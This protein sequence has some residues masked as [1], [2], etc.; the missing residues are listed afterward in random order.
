MFLASI[1]L[2]T[3]FG[4]LL[5]SIPLAALISKRSG[6]N[7]FETGNG[8]PGASNV[9]HNV[10]RIPAGFVLL[11]DLVKGAMAVLVS[12]Y[13]GL[14]EPWFVIPAAAA[15][16]GHWRSLFTGFKGGDGL[17]T[18]GGATIAMFPVLGS[19]S[20]TLGILVSLGGQR[21]PYTSL[22]GI[23]I[24]YP[25]LI[26]FI[27]TYG[28]DTSMALGIAAVSILVLTHALIGHKR[29]RNENQWQDNLDDALATK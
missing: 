16:F 26:A 22:M 1:L 10:G 6:I 7:I 4:Y 24:C 17:A 25:T 27:I 14:D 18:L 15:V 11:G 9:M 21:L 28:W 2:S 23:V 29:R 19:I 3:I 12:K 8:L 13:L 20:I 5:G